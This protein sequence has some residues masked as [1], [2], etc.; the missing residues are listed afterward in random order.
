M[1]LTHPPPAMCRHSVTG[2][3][4]ATPP[5]VL[6]LP[7]LPCD[8]CWW[9]SVADHRCTVAKPVVASGRLRVIDGTGWGSRGAR[10]VG[11]RRTWSRGTVCARVPCTAGYGRR[12][13]PL[14]AAPVAQGNRTSSRIRKGPR[15]GR[16]SWRARNSLIPSSLV[17]LPMCAPPHR[18]EIGY[19]CGV[20]PT[21][22][23]GPPCGPQ[24]NNGDT[25]QWPN[26][27]P[28]QRAPALRLRVLNRRRRTERCKGQTLRRIA[29]H[30]RAGTSRQ[31][32]DLVKTAALE[33]PW[34]FSRGPSTTMQG[35]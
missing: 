30:P 15:A 27:T 7:R 17:R 21:S 18:Y 2:L 12:E 28:P 25:D 19:F 3:Q 9:R 31:H 35:K 23:R 34:L 13:R 1:A 29:G 22:I 32:H 4:R 6:G 26:L 10:G 33:S 11:R 8:E 16:G 24:V 20:G 14:K 5:G